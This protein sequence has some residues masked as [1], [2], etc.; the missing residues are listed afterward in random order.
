MYSKPSR[1]QIRCNRGIVNIKT[2]VSLCVLQ[3]ILNFVGRVAEWCTNDDLVE[4]SIDDL[5]GKETPPNSTLERRLFCV[6]SCLQPLLRTLQGV[7]IR[8][9][10]VQCP[11]V[12]LDQLHEHMGQI[13]RWKYMESQG[14][15]LSVEHLQADTTMHQ[16]RFG[17]DVFK[18]E[19]EEEDEY[20]F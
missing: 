17:L 4:H 8:S 15:S 9:D 11:V 19:E 3:K 10:L 12:I 1:R 16:D 2:K 18:D 6:T 7:F 14:E 13:T 20:F 5:Y